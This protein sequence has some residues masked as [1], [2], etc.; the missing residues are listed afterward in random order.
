MVAQ[1]TIIIPGKRR[2]RRRKRISVEAPIIRPPS[3]WLISE[4]WINRRRGKQPQTIPIVN[5][6]NIYYEAAVLRVIE[7][8]AIIIDVYHT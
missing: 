3:T 7:I 4:Q 2:V 8:T 6:N 1:A 5:K